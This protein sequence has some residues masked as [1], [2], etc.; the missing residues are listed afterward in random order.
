MDLRYDAFAKPGDLLRLDFRLSDK[1][2][3]YKRRVYGFFDLVMD[4]IVIGLILWAICKFIT[5]LFASSLSYTMVSQFFRIH[6][7]PSEWSE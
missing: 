6:T 4:Y 3:I 5:C 1:A 7:P 2:W